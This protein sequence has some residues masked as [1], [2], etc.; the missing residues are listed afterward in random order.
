MNR[1]I[2]NMNQ[3]DSSASVMMDQRPQTWANIKMIVKYNSQWR[4]LA[5]Q[6]PLRLVGR[7]R[8][9]YDCRLIQKFVYYEVFEILFLM[10][11]E[12]NVILKI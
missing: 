12:N 4:Y 5:G 2:I 7:T 11:W 1:Y 8:I 6:A 10:V 3:V 9:E